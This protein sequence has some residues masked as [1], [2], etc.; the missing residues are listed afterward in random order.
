MA[1]KKTSKPAEPEI[2]VLQPGDRL[3]ISGDSRIL[4][5]DAERFVRAV[6]TGA[7][8][9]PVRDKV[10]LTIERGGDNG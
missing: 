1:T 7:T 2:I 4:S 5:D 6:S 10:T 8:V 9:I 3:I